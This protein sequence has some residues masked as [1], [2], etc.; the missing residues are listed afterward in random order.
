MLLSSSVAALA[1]VFRALLYISGIE[2]PRKRADLI[3]E[4]C[5]SF[6]LDSPLFD[7]LLQIARKEKKVSETEAKHLFD[8][9]V[10]EIDKLTQMVDRI[11]I[12]KEAE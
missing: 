6:Q 2:A 8:K 9:Y 1:P 11:V 10:E 7:Q 4:L 5:Q 3:R 12:E